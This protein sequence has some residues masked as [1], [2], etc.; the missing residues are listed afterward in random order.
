MCRSTHTLTQLTRIAGTSRASRRRESHIK[1]QSAVP[2]CRTPCNALNVD[3][4]GFSPRLRQVYVC[5]HAPIDMAHDLRHHRFLRLTGPNVIYRSQKK[6]KKKER[7]G[8]ASHGIGLA[9]EP[10]RGW[11]DDRSPLALLLLHAS[12]VFLV[13]LRTAFGASAGVHHQLNN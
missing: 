12:L 13:P 2:P 4:E 5:M 1:K 3:R 7:H 9:C 11:V 10:V 8:M 6:K